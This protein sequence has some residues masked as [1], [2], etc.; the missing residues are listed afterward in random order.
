LPIELVSN[1]RIVLNQ[2]R[3]AKG[4]GGVTVRQ[5]KLKRE[6]VVGTKQKLTTST[7]KGE[8]TIQQS[9][10]RGKVR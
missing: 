7:K 6:T 4:K 2:T 5:W 3:V 9:N 1:P 10:K 8:P